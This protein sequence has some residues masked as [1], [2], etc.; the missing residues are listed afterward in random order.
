[1]SKNRRGV[2]TSCGECAIV[3]SKYRIAYVTSNMNA[4]FALRYRQ[5]PIPYGHCYELVGH[6]KGNTRIHGSAGSWLKFSDDKVCHRLK[7]FVGRPHTPRTRVDGGDDDQSLRLYGGQ[8]L[9][10]PWIL[11]CLSR[12]IF[13]HINRQVG[14][15]GVGDNIC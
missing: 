5:Y 13:P 14:G 1:M 2:G 10:R 12:I 11:A 4:S 3:Y 8:T 9:A 15:S 6:P 7:T